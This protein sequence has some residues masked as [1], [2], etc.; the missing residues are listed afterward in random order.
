[1]TTTDTPLRFCGVNSLAYYS[2]EIF[3]NGGFTE[4]S[5]LAAS[6]GFGIINWTFAIPAIYTIDTF[7][8]RNLLLFTLPL[9]AV[10][11]LFIG[12]S[13][14]IPGDGTAR[15]ACVALGI[16]LYGIVYSPGQGPVPFTYSAE[17]YP[18]YVR[19]WG[20]SLATSTLWFFNFVLAITWP[21][22]FVAFQPQ[23]AFAWYAAWNLIGWW[24]VLCLMPETRARSLE[25]L[26]A[27][28]SVPT[29]LQAAHGL[30]QIPWFIRRYIFRQNVEL[31]PLINFDKAKKEGGNVEDIVAGKGEKV[32]H[33]V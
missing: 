20:M 8:R 11:L 1:M 18:L 17:A 6:L 4:Q 23:G 2:S 16:Y 10:F 14:W 32:R 9:L 5:A 30:K 29:H 33:S 19:T 25:E 13:F 28:F 12:F 7:G 27:V 22:L 26:D 3:V 15:T 24:G 21:S 31:A